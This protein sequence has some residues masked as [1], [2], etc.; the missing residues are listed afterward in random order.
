[1]GVLSH[2]VLGTAAIGLNDEVEL[3]YLVV[4]SNSDEL[5]K[6]IDVVSVNE[7]VKKLQ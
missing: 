3:R 4:E 7:R 5:L 1:V 2:L 6:Y